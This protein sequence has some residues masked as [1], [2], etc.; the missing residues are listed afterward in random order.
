MINVAKSNAASEAKLRAL[1]DFGFIFRVPGGSGR[2]GE[3]SSYGLVTRYQEGNIYVLVVP[4]NPKVIID[5][6]YS[7]RE[8]D[9]EAEGIL[10]LRLGK[11]TGIIAQEYRKIGQQIANNNKEFIYA[12]KHI[13]HVFYVDKYDD[14]NIRTKSSPDS[15]LGPPVWVELELLKMYL[16]I[17]HLWVIELLET[18][19]LAPR[20]REL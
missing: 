2:K 16:F 3:S 9:E 13:K 12:E 17:G 10:E 19:I 8:F 11:Q 20:L 6:K 1:R 14:S 18:E 7:E 5:R 4:Y 15:R